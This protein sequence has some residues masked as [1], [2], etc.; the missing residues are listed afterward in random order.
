[1]TGAIWFFYLRRHNI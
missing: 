1:M